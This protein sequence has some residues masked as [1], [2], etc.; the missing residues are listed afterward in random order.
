[1]SVQGGKFVDDGRTCLRITDPVAVVGVSKA[2]Y[3]TVPLT[4]EVRAPAG[5]QRGDRFLVDIAQQSQGRTV[6][7]AVAVFVMS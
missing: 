4:L 1:M 7:G 6:G 2:A 5:A 3:G